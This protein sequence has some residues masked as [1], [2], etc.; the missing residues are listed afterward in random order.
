MGK[1]STTKKQ[2]QKTNS[3]VFWFLTILHYLMGLAGLF[4]ATLMA[5]TLDSH[6]RLIN[7]LIAGGFTVLFALTQPDIRFRKMVTGWSSLA[8]KYPAEKSKYSS[9]V[10]H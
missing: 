3:Y 4:F 8:K 7:G 1:D 10:H 9:S 6:E 2:L 5:I